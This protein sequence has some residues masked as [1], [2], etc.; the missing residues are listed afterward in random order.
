MNP[1]HPV[2]LAVAH[3][4]ASIHVVL[5]AAARHTAPIPQALQVLACLEQTFLHFLQALNVQVKNQAKV[6]ACQNLLPPPFLQ[7][8]R[9]AL[10]HHHFSV[11]ALTQ[12]HKANVHVASV[13][14]QVVKAVNVV[15]S[16]PAY[17]HNL[18]RSCPDH[19]AVQVNLQACRVYQALHLHSLHGLAL[20]QAKV[21]AAQ[22]HVF[23]LHP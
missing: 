14:V 3:L 2:L 15:H 11:K 8:H 18:H 22:S 13:A 1:N 9:P 23:H 6:P 12:A 5:Q 21:A 10:Y 19:Q 7:V 16:H 17:H 20:C 4:K